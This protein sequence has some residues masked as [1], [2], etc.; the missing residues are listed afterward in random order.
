MGSER[1]RKY[2]ATILYYNPARRDSDC[3]VAV[4][5]PSTESSAESI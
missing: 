1:D 5:Y 2:I 3:E 4:T